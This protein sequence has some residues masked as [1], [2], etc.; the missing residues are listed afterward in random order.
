MRSR[1][2]LLFALLLLA[3]PAAAQETKS[4]PI[5]PRDGV[6]QLFNGKD[7]SGLYVFMQHTKFEDPRQV[8][9]V[10]DGMIHISGDGFGGVNTKQEYRDY[11]AV[12]E[13]KWGKRTWGIRTT[14]ARDSGLLFHCTGPDDA[15]G[16]YWMECF[17]SN[18]IEGGVGDL[19]VVS[20]K[21][22]KAQLQLTCEVSKDRDGEPVWT[23]GG[24]KKTFTTGRINW[25]DRDPDWKDD[26]DF[27]G[28]K[29][30]ESPWGQWTRLEVACEGD[31]VTVWV[32][33]QKVNEGFGA[34]PSAGKLTIQTEGAEIFVRRWELWPLGK[35]PAF[36]AK[37]LN[38]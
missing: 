18:I 32:N 37:A 13:F 11:H 14:H 8:F 10:H 28:A 26:L 35:A 3:A 31:H 33:G 25:R 9:T 1:L 21:E 7:L 36:D 16:G 23:P 12:C 5:T 4:Q 34:H 30:V 2:T 19:L 38:P 20:T 24:E 17:E 27:R 29:D 6:I 22:N 15:I